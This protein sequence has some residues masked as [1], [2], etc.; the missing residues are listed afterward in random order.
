GAPG[1]MTPERVPAQPA[2]R[3]A[4]LVQI[5]ER[6]ARAAQQLKHVRNVGEPE[7]RQ[8]SAHSLAGYPAPQVTR[9]TTN[10]TVRS[11]I[12]VRGRNRRVAPVRQLLRFLEEPGGMRGIRSRHQRE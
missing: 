5:R 12:V 11:P 9:P 1:R 4:S 6:R 2:M 8:P 10:I 3:N 7:T